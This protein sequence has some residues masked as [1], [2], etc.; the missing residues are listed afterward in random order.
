MTWTNEL[1]DA[2][3]RR[4]PGV[5]CRF[6][7]ADVTAYHHSHVAGADVFPADKHDVGSLHH[8]VGCLD[9]P[10]ETFGLDHSQGFEW[11]ANGL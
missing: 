11:H 4:G 6:Y 9:R 7:C 2:P 8:H 10:N 1:A 3:R 5:C